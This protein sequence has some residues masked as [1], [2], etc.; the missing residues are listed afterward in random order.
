MFKGVLLDLGGVVF[1]GDTPLPGAIAAIERLRAAGLPLRFVT[2]ITRQ[3]RRG[4]IV[5]LRGM[6]IAVEQDEVLTPAIAARAHR[7]ASYGNL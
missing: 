1:T 7:C 6:G 3:P 4:V 2:N 5:Q